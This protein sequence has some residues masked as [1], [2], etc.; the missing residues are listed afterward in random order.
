MAQ[1]AFG[2][3]PGER[4]LRADLGFEVGE[5]LTLR[6]LAAHVTAVQSPGRGFI[7]AYPGDPIPLASSLNYEK[8]QDRANLS[9][10]QVGE[11]GTVSLFNGVLPVAASARAPQSRGHEARVKN[12]NND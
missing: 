6:H 8:G 10:V 5:S 2:Y 11:D 1:H 9:L 7:T 3:G 4:R 12:F